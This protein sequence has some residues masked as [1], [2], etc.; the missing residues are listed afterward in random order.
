MNKKEPLSD[1]EKQKRKIMRKK[2]IRNVMTIPEIIIVIIVIIFIK[3]KY[4]E[5][6]KNVH[7][8]IEYQSSPY[9][10]IME[11]TNDTIEVKKKNEDKIIEAAYEIKF[12]KKQMTILRGYFDA[13]FKLKSGQKTVTMD[14]V[15]S[16]IGKKS[17]RSMIHNNPD[18][19]KTS[20]YK[21][22]EL[23]DY[24][25]NSD[26]HT[27]GYK[28]TKDDNNHI[29][30]V[31]SVWKAVETFAEKTIRIFRYSRIEWVFN[32]SFRSTPKR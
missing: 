25:Q 2:I 24:E 23:E 3:N 6:G 13:T 5:H 11:R 7:Q 21:N 9:V 32:N 10:Y 15:V 30:A 12:P 22:Y 31:E 4:E 1:L 14:K 8:V 26:Y 20:V 19:L 16:D 17:I 27:R 18:F 29:V 28:I